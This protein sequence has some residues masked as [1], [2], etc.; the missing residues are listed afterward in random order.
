MK[1]E[2]YADG[3]S[4]PNPGPGGYGTMLVFSDVKK[5]LSAGFKYTTVNR[6]ELLGVIVG[7][8]ALKKPCNV[9]IY[10][11]SKYVVS[12]IQKGWLKR[13]KKSAFKGKSNVDLWQRYLSAS[14]GHQIRAVWVRGHSG[15]PGNETCDRLAYMA[16]SLPSRLQLSD[17]GVKTKK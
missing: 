11:D 13:W 17:P 15:V 8:E 10:S 16:A 6:M 5:R 14:K 3:S 4:R 9:T 7:L 1:V 12:P 2:I